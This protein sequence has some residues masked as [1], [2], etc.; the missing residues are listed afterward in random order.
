M[1]ALELLDDGKMRCAT[2]GGEYKILFRRGAPAPAADV[3]PVLP[4]VPA[5]AP[6][7]R[8]CPQ[9]SPASSAARRF[10]R[11][12]PSRRMTAAGSVPFAPLCIRPGLHLR[13]WAGFPP[14]LWPYRTGNAGNTPTLPQS[15]S[16]RLAARLCAPPVIFCC[17]ENCTSVLVAPPASGPVS[18]RNGRP[19]SSVPSRWA[20]GARW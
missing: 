5:C 10:A 12:A 17:P 2:H 1:G 16:A 11:F 18:A 19:T 15:K 9:C 7:T 4:A 14:S 3:P 6:I 8:I 20:F 13:R